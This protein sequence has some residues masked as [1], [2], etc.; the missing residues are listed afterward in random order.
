MLFITFE[1][2]LKKQHNYSILK[3][4]YEI[5]KNSPKPIEWNE[6][7]NNTIKTFNNLLKNKSENERVFQHFLEKNP[8]MVP[9]AFGIFGESGHVPHNNA[10][11]AQPKLTGLT[12]KIPDFLWLG[13]DSSSIYTVFIEIEN[14]AKKW[15]TKNG[16][17][18]SD[19][20]QAQ[21]QLTEWK[22]WFAN[23]N[24]KDLFYQF[25]GIHSD[26]FEKKMVKPRYILIYGSRSEFK[27]KPDLNRKRSLLAREDEEYMT[28]DRL[29]P[30]QKASNVITCK[31]KDGKFFAKYVPPTFKLGPGLASYR[32]EILNMESAI[33]K[34]ELKEER[35]E[36]LISRLDYWD[37]FAK[38][39]YVG[40]IDMGDWE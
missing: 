25:Y 24:H 31:V 20:T 8:A 15:F 16:Q 9:E 38:K 36:F 39:E 14:T 21:N 11:I 35:K 40:I 6:Y 22:E 7:S 30:N 27:E 28:F 2:R 37:S 32:S 26:I 17:Q 29:N 3:K 10:L 4:S 18:H 34:S 1:M 33:N 5:K 19:F 23:S 12:T 13:M